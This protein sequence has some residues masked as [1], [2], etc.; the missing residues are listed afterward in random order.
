MVMDWVSWKLIKLKKEA[1][2]LYKKINRNKIKTL[3]PSYPETTQI[4]YAIAVLLLCQM[5]LPREDEQIFEC[6]ADD[7]ACS[8]IGK[9]AVKCVQ[10]FPIFFVAFLLISSIYVFFVRLCSN[11]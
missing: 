10:V 6:C 9:W 7:H 2:V 5:P 4:G 1:N 8:R 11:F 3:K